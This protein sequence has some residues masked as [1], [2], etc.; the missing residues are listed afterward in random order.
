MAKILNVRVLSSVLKNIS[1]M[2]SSKIKTLTNNAG[3]LMGV[4]VDQRA[5]SG[6]VHRARL[7]LELVREEHFSAS[8][9]F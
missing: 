5:P 8:F 3:H 4:R 6:A 7:Q 9:K 1:F 2:N